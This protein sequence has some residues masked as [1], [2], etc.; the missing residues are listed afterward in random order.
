MDVSLEKSSLLSILQN[1]QRALSGK[2]SLPVLNGILLESRDGS[3][4]AYA[5]DLEIS[6]KDETEASVATEGRAVVFG[7]LLSDI[8]KSLDD[9][10]ISLVMDSK[11]NK[12]TVKS[13]NAR[14]DLNTL[15][16]ED[17]PPF[18]ETG[19]EKTINISK[20][21]FV[22][23]SKQVSIAAS[24]DEGR[25]VLTGVLIEINSEKSRMVA[26]D[27][28]RLS[29]KK[30][31]AANKEHTS[32]IVPRRAIEDIIKIISDKGSIKIS[33]SDNQIS[34]R[35]EGLVFVSRLIGGQYPNFEQLFPKEF[36]SEIEIN[37][38]EILQSVKRMALLSPSTPIVL[39]AK[40]NK[41][42]LAN[43][44]ADVG[45]G[46]EEISLKNKTKEIEIAFNSKYLIE[47]LS[48]LKDD[49]IKIQLTDSFQ[50]GL[51]RGG[52]NEDFEYLIMPVR[53]N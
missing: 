8:V 42:R 31:K 41:L 28:Y 18:P 37:R 13:T 20:K 1:V 32:I 35:S 24:R 17:Y 49:E 43:K 19:Q 11:N 33:F 40:D 5:T 2:S 23:G 51:I 50:P 7:N 39:K 48:V 45:S 36:N 10:K 29:V 26:T 53:L 4:I 21:D 14:F 12:L 16:V 46:E 15:P 38:E 34:F 22:E 3:L 52:K 25:P 9:G 6:I 30:I 44:S 47:G 27:S